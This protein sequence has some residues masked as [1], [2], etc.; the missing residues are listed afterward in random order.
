MSRS[1]VS[2]GRLEPYAHG[3]NSELGVLAEIA[4]LCETSVDRFACRLALGLGEVAFDR[5]A[6]WS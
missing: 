3:S 1:V 2:E 6:R 5:S 4:V